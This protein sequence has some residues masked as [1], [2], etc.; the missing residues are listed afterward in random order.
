[1]ADETPDHNLRLA[2]ITYWY[3]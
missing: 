1:M 3:C 2:T